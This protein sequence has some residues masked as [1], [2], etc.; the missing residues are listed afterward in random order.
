MDAPAVDV[1]K[2]RPAPSLATVENSSHRLPPEPNPTR[3]RPPIKQTHE[4]IHPPP[5]YIKVSFHSPLS[6]APSLGLKDG[7]RDLK[8]TRRRRTPSHHHHRHQTHPPPARHRPTKTH[9]H[10][11]PPVYIKVSFHI[12]SSRA[13]PRSVWTTVK[14]TLK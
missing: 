2:I 5:V 6:R 4:T 8:V 10:T 9:D 13:T 14:G 3:Y 7:E 11:L 1:D 12:S